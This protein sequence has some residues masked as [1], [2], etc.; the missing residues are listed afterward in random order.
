M[1]KTTTTTAT[2]SKTRKTKKLT[3]EEIAVK[4]AKEKLKAERLAKKLERERKKALKA[5]E[6]KKKEEAR[7]TREAKKAEKEAK[8]LA[9]EQEAQNNVKVEALIKKLK[10][11][12]EFVQPTPMSLKEREHLQKI[13]DSPDIRKDSMCIQTYGKSIVKVLEHQDDEY[14]IS[15]DDIY[16]FYNVKKKVG[17]NFGNVFDTWLNTCKRTPWKKI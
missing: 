10:V 4:E 16:Y 2:K 12:K 15:L 5:Q 1:P 8:R 9:K 7:A 3:P 11:Q 17:I 6:L 13:L 14:V